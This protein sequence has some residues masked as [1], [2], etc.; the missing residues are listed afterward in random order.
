V[1][2]IIPMGNVPCKTYLKKRLITWVIQVAKVITTKVGDLT[3][4]WDKQDPQIDHHLNN[5][6]NIPLWQIELQRLRTH[7]INSCK[8]QY[9]TTRAPKL[10]SVTW[11]CK[12]G[13]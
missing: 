3:Q 13:K 9:P 10:L 1:V 11:R 2:G 8:C 6:N 7:S 12:W 4:T 5:F